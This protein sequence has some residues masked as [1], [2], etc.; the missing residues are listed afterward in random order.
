MMKTKPTGAFTH[1]E[2][3]PTAFIDVPYDTYLREIN[4]L[5]CKKIDCLL[6]VSEVSQK[7]G[8]DACKMLQI[9]S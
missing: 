3:I 5:A 9:L 2:I 7:K 6:V 1:L 4:S 8:S